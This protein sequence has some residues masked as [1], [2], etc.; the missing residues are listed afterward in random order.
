MKLRCLALRSRLRLAAVWGCLVWGT[1]A[2]LAHAQAVKP[3]LWEFE[4]RQSRLSWAAGPALDMQKI[5]QQLQAQ[6][7]DMEP[8]LRR[9]LEEN[10]RSAGVVMTQGRSQRLCIP[11]EQ[12]NLVRIAEQHQQES[13]RFSLLESG[14]GFVRGQLQCTQPQSQG[15]YV[16]TL[17][18]P[19]QL[20]TRVELKTPQGQLVVNA[21]A[22]WLGTD[23]ADAPAL[24]QQRLHERSLFN[25]DK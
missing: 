14:A 7:L 16:S 21:G 4:G 11:S 10:L 9:V 3:G 25:S 23:C 6:M 17:V 5:N 22:K 24:G 1:T 13:C 19:E 20:S 12:A 8:G 18:S 2:E 15:S